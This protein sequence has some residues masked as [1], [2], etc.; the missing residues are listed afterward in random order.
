[1]IVRASSNGNND[2]ALAIR[3]GPDHGV[4]TRFEVTRPEGYVVLAQKSRVRTRAGFGEA[5]YTAY[6]PAFDTPLMRSRGL[7]YLQE[8]RTDGYA[9]LK[10]LGVPSI[11]VPGKQVHAVV[12]RKTALVL[13]ITE[14]VDPF[15]AKYVGVRQCVREVLVTVAA[16]RDAAYAYARSSA[17]ARGL[18]QF[19]PQTYAMV[20]SNYPAAG[21]DPDFIG[22][23]RDH[24]NAARAAIALLD[25]ELAAL[26]EGKRAWFLR[27]NGDRY[28]DA[29]FA[30]AYNWNATKV[31]RAYVASLAKPIV[32]RKRG[33]R[34]RVRPKSWISRLPAET[35]KYVEIQRQ[36]ADALGV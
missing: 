5:V 32:V 18:M 3:V 14:H 30:A 4:A 1:M 35:R 34:V 16:N 9:E 6:D 25:L 24:R 22:G 17:E 15:R 20:R 27:P 13:M 29:Y 8:V 19:V 28:A 36:V 11:A 26:P 33:R 23:M 31:A 12:P 21:L 2:R 7:A 10:R